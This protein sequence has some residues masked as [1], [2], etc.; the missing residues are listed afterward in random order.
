[1]LRVQYRMNNTIMGWSNKMFYDQ[2]LKAHES[3][4]NHQLKQLYANVDENEEILLL[5]DTSGC[6]MGESG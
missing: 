1:M 3:V 2:K 6:G 5:I 4:E